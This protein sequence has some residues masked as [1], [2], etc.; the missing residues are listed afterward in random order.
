MEMK[1][2]Y[3]SKDI[4]NFALVGHG[5]SGKTILSEAIL[6]CSGAVGRIGSID[7]GS[8]IS[9]YHEDEKKRKISI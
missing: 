7:S 8:T 6:Y 4:R 1:K 5:A 9:D 2:E 3:H